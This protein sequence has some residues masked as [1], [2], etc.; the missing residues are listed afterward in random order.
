MRVPNICNSYLINTSLQHYQR[1]D[2][3]HATSHLKSCLQKVLGLWSMFCIAV[4]GMLVW[5]W[6][7]FCLT[8]SFEGEGV[9]SLPAST[10]WTTDGL[11]VQMSL[12]NTSALLACKENKRRRLVELQIFASCIREDIKKT[13][14]I[15]TGEKISQIK[16]NVYILFCT[17]K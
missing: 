9:S 6:W 5:R 14:N 4:I 1:Q 2:K 16:K 7:W 13:F 11:F 12:A 8:V 15:L 3:T 17:S 10:A